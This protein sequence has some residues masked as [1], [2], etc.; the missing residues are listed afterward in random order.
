MAIVPDQPGFCPNFSQDTDA[1]SE[2]IAMSRLMFTTSLCLC[3]LVVNSRLDPCKQASATCYRFLSL[4]RSHGSKRAI[5]LSLR[6]N[7]K[8]AIALNFVGW[9]EQ[10]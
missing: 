9:V 2:T 5:A 10:K 3:V 1:L 4:R 7:F 6:G 8:T